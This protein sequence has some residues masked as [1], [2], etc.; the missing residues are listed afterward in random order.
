VVAP[1]SECLAITVILF[2]VVCPAQERHSPHLSDE[3]MT[4]NNINLTVED[5]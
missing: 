2:F 4:D 1:S 3:A 5:M